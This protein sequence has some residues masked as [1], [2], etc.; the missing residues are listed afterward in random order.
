M[1]NLTLSRKLRGAP[2]CGLL[3][4]INNVLVAS[5]NQQWDP[6]QY[7]EDF[8]LA[9]VQEIHLAGYNQET[10][11]TG[12]PVLIDTHD[13]P[14]SDA[15]WSLSI[16]SS[17]A[18]DRFPHLS[19][20]ILRCRPGQSC[21][22]KQPGPAQ[23]CWTLG[24]RHTMQSYGEWQ[25]EFARAL[26]NPHLPVPPG[27]TD[28]LGRPGS[29]GSRSTE[30]TFIAGLIEALQDSFPVTCRIVGAEFFQAMARIYVAR[31]P[32]DS[33]ILLE[34]GEDSQPLSLILSRPRRSL[35]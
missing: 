10:A 30:T 26:M 18:R 9:K 34:Y 21:R 19:S 3:L 23:S 8:P 35:T 11:E 28:P 4:D 17:G 22:L 29:S 13:R 33:P 14:V 32:P 7:L 20:G 27:L 5:T 25:S 6:M 15:V 24:W 1:Q 2:A 16:G 31:N 12:Q